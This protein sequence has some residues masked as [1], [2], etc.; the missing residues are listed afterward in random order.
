MVA[1]ILAYAS[2][3]LVS[4]RPSKNSGTPRLSSSCVASHRNQC[5]CPGILYGSLHGADASPTSAASSDPFA[6]ASMPSSTSATA[7]STAAAAAAT[8]LAAPAI[9]PRDMFSWTTPPR[10]PRAGRP[11][12]KSGPWAPPSFAAAAA[13]DECGAVRCC[14]TALGPI[15]SANCGGATRSSSVA[16]GVVPAVAKVPA[17]APV[18]CVAIVPWD[19]SSSSSAAASG[20]PLRF[21]P[22]RG[23]PPPCACAC[24]AVVAAMAALA[25]SLARV[26]ARIAVSAGSSHA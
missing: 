23:G 12:C 2:G 1:R 9:C 16:A 5:E 18:P 11:G 7:A 4:D 20:P 17:V 10:S 19:A 13:T 6:S 21:S 8:S 14:R 25:A 15:L 24:A 3:V 22:T 26:A